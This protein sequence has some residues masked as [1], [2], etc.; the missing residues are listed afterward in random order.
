MRLKDK[1]T[2]VVG[3]SAGMGKAIADRFAR[4]GAKVVASARRREKLEELGRT[5]KDAQGEFAP[6]AADITVQ[7]EAESILDFA[8]E[9]FGHL[10]VLVNVAGIMDDMSGVGELSNDMLERVMQVNAYGP[11]YT[12]RRAVQIFRKQGHGGNIINVTSTGAL[13]NSS[14][15]AY[16]IS[17][18]AL[19]AA[20]TSTAFMYQKMGIRCNILAPGGCGNTEI[21]ANM[22]APDMDGYNRIKTLLD[23]Q[24]PLGTPEDMA[25]TALF[26]A[27]DE[28][29]MITGTRIT[30]DGGWFCV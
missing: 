11:I 14:G 15:V 8:V 21:S 16:R 25:N 13:H 3:A 28:S 27:S 18:A 29:K 7:K 5:L 23:F 4:E 12:M 24:P 10:D 1:V 17:K 22:P 20:S 26:L 19:E 30:V 2:V 9:H 6:F